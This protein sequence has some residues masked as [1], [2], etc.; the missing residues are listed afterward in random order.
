M[1][2]KKGDTVWLGG[3]TTRK[4][5]ITSKHKGYYVVE[6]NGGY[7]CLVKDSYIIGL[8]KASTIFIPKRIKKVVL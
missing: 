3:I 6:F 5:T 2:Y 8:D 7:K 1:N 4:A